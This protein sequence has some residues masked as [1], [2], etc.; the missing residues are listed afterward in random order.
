MNTRCTSL[1]FLVL[2]VFLSIGCTSDQESPVDDQGPIVIDQMPPDMATTHPTH[3]PHGGDL[4]ELGGEA[5]HAEVVHHA[6]E[7]VVYLLDSAATT[8][9]ATDAEK[10]VISLRSGGA[11]ESFDLLASR[12]DDDPAAKS[13]RFIGKSPQLIE[14]LDGGAT[15]MLIIQIEGKSYN[16]EISHS[17]DH[18]H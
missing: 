17:H 6:G 8:T 2:V 3:G 11:V 12:Q 18:D 5:L 7:I 15:G 4:I 9:V 16:G 13:S 14:A 1:C 10:L